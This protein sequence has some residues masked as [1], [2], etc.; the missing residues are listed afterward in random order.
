MV[1]PYP[2]VVTFIH[3][4]LGFGIPTIRGEGLEG[5]R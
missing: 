5:S 4:D 1:G 3:P 2:L